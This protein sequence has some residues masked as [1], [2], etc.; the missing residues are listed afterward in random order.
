MH[1]LTLDNQIY[2]IIQSANH[3]LKVMADDISKLEIAFSDKAQAVI[4]HYKNRFNAL[5]DIRPVLAE[6]S[7]IELNT[8][9]ENTDAVLEKI[10]ELPENDERLIL[11]KEMGPDIIDDISLIFTGLDLY[12]G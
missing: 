4:S 2:P 11:L 9:K 6:I 3:K 7:D 1:A 10:K 5:S 12:W 8:T